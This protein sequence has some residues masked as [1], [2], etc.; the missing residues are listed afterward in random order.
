[1]EPTYHDIESTAIYARVKA[2]RGARYGPIVPAHLDE[3]IKQ[4]TRASGELELAFGR[5]PKEGDILRYQHVALVHSPENYSIHF[6]KL[7]AWQR[8]FPQLTCPLRFEGGRLFRRHRP[9][10]RG[11]EAKWEECA[12]I[13]WVQRWVAIPEVF[14]NSDIEAS[15]PI[16]AVVFLGVVGAKHQCRPATAQEL[17]RPDPESPI[18]DPT[19]FMFANQRFCEMLVEVLGA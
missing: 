17:L 7:I 19:G 14:A 13:Q 11:V 2:L 8:Q 6:G 4:Y 16:L 10:R 9:E 1:M 15:A 5:E 3:H 12:G 18:P